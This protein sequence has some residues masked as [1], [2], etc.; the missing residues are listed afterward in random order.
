[1]KRK[2]IT[3]VLLSAL[4]VA[5]SAVSVFAAHYDFTRISDKKVFPLIDVAATPE[6]LADIAADVPDYTIELKDGNNYPLEDYMKVMKENPTFTEDQAIEE[7]NKM[8]LQVVSVSAITNVVAQAAGQQLEIGVND[9]KTPKTVNELKEMGYTVKFEYTVSVGKDAPERRTGLINASAAPFNTDFEYK[10]ILSKDG[11]DMASEWTKVSR[12]SSLTDLKN[13]TEA[14]MKL[15]V[16]IVSYAKPGDTLKL[17]AGAGMNFKGEA[18]DAAALATASAGTVT[19]D[20]MAVVFPTGNVLEVKAAAVGTAN[21]TVAFK[22][23]ARE[24]GTVKVAVV[25]KEKDGALAK[26]E[27]LDPEAKYPLGAQ[28]IVAVLKDAEGAMLRDPIKDSDVKVTVDGAAV[29]ASDLDVSKGG[30]LGISVDFAEAGTKSVVVMDKEG[31]VELGKFDV[32]VENVVAT[33]EP[34]NYVLMADQAFDIN[35]NPH[36]TI[37]VKGYKNGIELDKAKFHQSPRALSVFVDDVELSKTRFAAH[38]NTID[39]IHT[40]GNFQLKLAAAA[41]YPELGDH[42]ITLKLIEG[43]RTTLLTKDPLTVQVTNTT[44]QVESMELVAPIVVADMD[45]VTAAEIETAV[46]TDNTL[47]TVLSAGAF[48]QA[49]ID[50]VKYFKDTKVLNIWIKPEHG[51]KHF[52]LTYKGKHAVAEKIVKA[53]V[54]PKATG[55]PAVGG[56]QPG[57]PAF[58]NNADTDPFRVLSFTTKITT[59]GAN[60]AEWE[61]NDVVEYVLTLKAVDGYT[62]K[63]YADSDVELTNLG[64][65][66]AAA[67]FTVDPADA[68]RATVKLT[69]TMP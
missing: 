28:T 47:K 40:N 18:A 15:G 38:T 61:S 37:T 52:A 41:P 24:V 4:M 26:V 44:P 36:V 68:T 53:N 32:K 46:T 17:V 27:P 30:Q 49:Q 35:A 48:A 43:D 10:V 62:F 64:G 55:F 50:D 21:L 14:K 1:M 25:V 54:A 9:S 56:A 5:S 45:A 31:K 33:D 20:K 19:S 51:G 16:D 11:K 13:V 58:T 42:K 7:L 23:G 34:D 2:H 3:A 69:Y 66:V 29:D 39:N 6:Y 8:G 57:T 63:D 60:S 65:N 12:V 59:P 67:D 22:V